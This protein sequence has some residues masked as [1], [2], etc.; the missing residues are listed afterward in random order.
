VLV[1]DPPLLHA[2]SRCV[3]LR[4]LFLQICVGGDLASYINCHTEEDSRLSE[5][6]AKHIMFQLLNGLVYLHDLSI[7]HNGVFSWSRTI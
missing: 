5:E 4:C 7:S 1:C 6:E 2:D 3:C